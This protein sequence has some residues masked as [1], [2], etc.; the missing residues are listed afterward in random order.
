LEWEISSKAPEKD[1]HLNLE[2]IVKL[3]RKKGFANMRRL[4]IPEKLAINSFLRPCL[5]IS[6][7]ATAVPV[8][9]NNI[10]ANRKKRRPQHK[11]TQ[12]KWSV[13]KIST[14]LMHVQ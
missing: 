1:T 5:S 10:S 14:N 4:T 2:S 6:D 13:A 7:D 3:C 12:R 11:K 9:F 8:K